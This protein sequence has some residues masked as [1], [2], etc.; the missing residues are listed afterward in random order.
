MFVQRSTDSSTGTGAGLQPTTAVMKTLFAPI[1][2]YA[3][4]ML[5]VDE[6]H[7]L[8]IEECGNPSGVPVVFLH[9]GPAS[10]CRPDQRRFFD[11]NR[12]RVILFDQRGCGRSRPC[13]DVRD[14]TTTHL[15]QD[16]E[17]IREALG[18]ERWLLFA[19]SWGATL[20]LVYAQHWPARVLGL[21]LRGVFLARLRDMDW[22]LKSGPRFVYPQQWARLVRGLTATELEDLPAAFYDRLHGE[23]RAER[24]RVAR[25]WDWW[26][27]T[28]ALGHLGIPVAAECSDE[29][30]AA[31]VVVELHYA[32]NRYFLRENQILEDAERIPAVPIHIIHGRYDL[33]CPVE[34][35]YS[36]H[37]RLPGSEFEVLAESGHIAAGGSM[38]DALCRST[39]RMLERVDY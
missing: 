19:G 25:E 10:G 36:L 16:L 33:V 28:V 24:F 1:E 9:G 7:T 22:F 32:I 31:R 34:T 18:I 17:S 26:G 30:L 5:A 37:Q 11:P 15:L 23:D 3:T 4:R 12:Y 27:S 14:N 38:I 13:G 21:I 35:G 39:Q 8:Y 29:A 2:P 20:A 6:R